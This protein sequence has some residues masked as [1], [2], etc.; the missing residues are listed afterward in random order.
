VKPT[1]LN[2]TRHEKQAVHAWL[3]DHSVDYK[4]VPVEAELV[5]DDATYEWRI[6]LFWRDA[7]GGL[8]LTADGSDMRRVVVR[9]REL[10]PLPW[11]ERITHHAIEGTDFMP[12]GW[13]GGCDT[14]ASWPAPTVCAICSYDDTGLPRHPVT[15]PCHLTEE[16]AA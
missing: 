10:Y 1:Y 2:L 11:P 13:C 9:R 3:S 6:P 7:D 4:R 8:A 14:C 12:S 5:R 16:G 15:W